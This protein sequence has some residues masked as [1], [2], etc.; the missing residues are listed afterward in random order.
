MSALAGILYHD[1]R[2]VPASDRATLTRHCRPLGPDGGGTFTAPGLILQSHIQTFDRL[3]AIERQPW[4]SPNGSVITW[5][6]RL[7]NRD[8]LLVAFHHTLGSDIT[9]VA[10]VAAAYDKWGIDACRRLVGDWTLAVWDARKQ[11]LIVARDYMGN[12]PL[13]YIETPEGLAWSTCLD[14]LLDRFDR[15]TEPDETYVAGRLTFGVPAGTTPFRGIKALRPG[16]CLVGTRGRAADVRRYWIFEPR[17][18]RYSNPADYTDHLRSLLTEAVRTR[19]RAHRT[20]WAHLSGGWDSSSIVCLAHALIKRQLVEAP[21]IQPLSIVCGDSPES[22]ERPFMAVVEEWCGLKTHAFEL[23]ESPGFDKLLG[24]HRPNPYIP[25]STLESVVQASH[26]QIVLSGELGDAVML[27]NSSDFLSLLEPLH[28]GHPFEA[29]RLTLA[30]S[31]HRER[32]AWP[33][34]TS[35]ARTY[36]PASVTRRRERRRLLSSRAQRAKVSSTDV[37]AVF[38]VTPALLAMA[39][40]PNSVPIPSVSEWPKA[41]RRL[42]EN[43][44]RAADVGALCTWDTLPEVKR[45]FPYAHRPLVEYVISVPQL[46]LWDPVVYRMGMKRALED[47]LPPKLLSRTTKGMPTTAMVR[48]MRLTILNTAL[49]DPRDW[50]LVKRGYVESSALNKAV[51]HVLSGTADQSGYIRTC[52]GLEA[53]LRTLSTLEQSRSAL[54]A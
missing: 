28:Q 24:H 23:Q 2:P 42:V 18:L 22:D 45:T 4:T 29:L 20:V 26:D 9:D 40:E 27:Q 50:Q 5:D 30:F 15:F 39:P 33:I 51:Q 21:A 52:I 6:G 43:L 47:V 31:R 34:L 8:D 3:S 25:D 48:S 53:W 41:K 11:S 14:A 32:P 54:T 37:A 44:Y 17:R 46:A 38:G 13:Y 1:E 16:H 10:L 36:L 49:G 35:L 19:L 7:D 12:R